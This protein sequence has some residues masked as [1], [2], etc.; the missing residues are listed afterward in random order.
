MNSVKRSIDCHCFAAAVR[1]RG[2]ARATIHEWDRIGDIVL[3]AGVLS[4]WLR[5][6]TFLKGNPPDEAALAKARETF[7]KFDERIHDRLSQCSFLA[8]PHLTYA[9]VGVAHLLTQLKSVGG[10]EVTAAVSQKW[11]E[12]CTGRASYVGLN[13]RNAAPAGQ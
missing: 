6:T 11:L 5:N 9:D 8:G 3:G 7:A 12:F 1:F 4:P 10:P 13:Q 2:R